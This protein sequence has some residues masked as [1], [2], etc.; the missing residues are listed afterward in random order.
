MK[1]SNMN[2][3][4]LDQI[5]TQQLHH[6]MAHTPAVLLLPL[7]SVEPH[8]PHMPL[9]TDRFLSEA[10]AEYA[11]QQLRYEGINAWIAPACAYAVTEFACDFAGAISLPSSLYKNLLMTL[12]YI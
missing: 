5:S 3:F 6:V 12:V 1:Q 4:Y 7:G 8:G 10:S 2:T 9:G 11:C